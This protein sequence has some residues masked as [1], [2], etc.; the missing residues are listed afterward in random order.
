[1]GSMISDRNFDY[2]ETLIQEA[3]DAG[4]ELLYGGKRF[5]H[6]TWKEGYYFTPTILR[7]VTKSMRIANEECFAPIMTIMEYDVRDIIP[8]SLQR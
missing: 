6:S 5:K 8:S 7:G 3:V 2:L 4:A 1:M